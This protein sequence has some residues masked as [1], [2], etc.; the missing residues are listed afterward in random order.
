M[1]NKRMNDLTLKDHYKDW[2]IKSDFN[3]LYNF[4]VEPMPSQSINSSEFNQIFRRITFDLNKKYLN[5]KYFSRWPPNRKFWVLAVKQGDKNTNSQ[6]HY[7]GLLHSPSNIVI[8][9]FSDLI[10]SFNKYMGVNPI[11]GKRKKLFKNYKDK[12]YVGC[13]D[14]DSKF[15][16]YVEKTR[17]KK[18]SINYN[19]RDLRKDLDDDNFMII[20]LNE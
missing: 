19:T 20:G 13:D 16:I 14:L 8:D 10:F 17:T 12:F 2:L 11:N 5:S 18:G 9:V 7:H 3:F 15:L 6:L 4:V 1:S